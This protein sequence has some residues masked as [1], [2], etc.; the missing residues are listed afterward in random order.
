[1]HQDYETL[2]L[3]QQL[4]ISFLFI[5]VPYGDLTKKQEKSFT[6]S[7]QKKEEETT[8]SESQDK[9]FTFLD[10]SPIWQP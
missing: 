8:K 1:M 5:E 6:C 3:L 7:L 4:P 2:A 9:H 10:T